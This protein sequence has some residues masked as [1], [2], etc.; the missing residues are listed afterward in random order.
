MPMFLPYL[1]CLIPV[2]FGAVCVFD[3][4][5][6][7]ILVPVG[8]FIGASGLAFCFH[9]QNFCNLCL[10]GILSFLVLLG[11]VAASFFLLGPVLVEGL[12]RIS[13]FSG[14]DEGVII[15][16][17]ASFFFGLWGL[18]CILAANIVLVDRSMRA[19]I[20]AFVI[21]VIA[22]ILT[23]IWPLLAAILSGT[24]FSALLV[25]NLRV[26]SLAHRQIFRRER[27]DHNQGRNIDG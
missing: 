1:F 7:L 26:F 25:W 2:G 21:C 17:V 3:R 12:S 9:P 4:N 6:S 18:A 5:L 19:G 22:I 24:V 23:A 16:L 27:P 14:A 10:R 20:T 8:Y 13:G 15:V 11:A